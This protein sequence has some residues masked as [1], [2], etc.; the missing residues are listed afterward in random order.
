VP[1]LKSVRIKTAGLPA[2]VFLCGF[3][4]GHFLLELI[5]R[6]FFKRPGASTVRLLNSGIIK[7]QLN[8]AG[9]GR[10]VTVCRQKVNGGAGCKSVPGDFRL[11][12]R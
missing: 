9:N 2:V 5:K 3:G 7:K 10:A 8:Y 4:K 6:A 11:S 1:V 12:R